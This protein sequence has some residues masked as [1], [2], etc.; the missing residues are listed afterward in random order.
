MLKEAE[1]DPGS[2]QNDREFGFRAWGFFELKVIVVNHS[3]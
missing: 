3:E 1:D 2:M